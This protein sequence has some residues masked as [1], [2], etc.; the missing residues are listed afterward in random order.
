MSIVSKKWICIGLIGALIASVPVGLSACGKKASVT[1]TTV[2]STASTSQTAVQPKSLEEMYEP[3]LIAFL[4]KTLTIDGKTITAGEYNYHCVSAFQELSAYAQY[5]YYPAT[6]TGTLDLSAVCDLTDNGSGTWGDYLLEYVKK[7]I[8][9]NYILGVLA[10]KNNLT[11]SAETLSEIDT[12]MQE[13]ETQA[14]AAGLTG[15]TFI[16]QYCGDKM[17]VARFRTIIE[18]FYLADLYKTN[19]IDN[20]VFSE[21]ETALP[22]VRH[23]LY[24]AP[25]NGTSEENATEEEVAKAQ[26]NAESTLLQINGYDDMVLIGDKH[27]RD[28]TALEANEYTV[29]R[30]DMVK[31]FEDWC[32]D[33]S[34][35]AGDKEIVRTDFGF[36]VM[37]FVGRTE[38]DEEQKKAIV[39]NIIT[40]E[41][42]AMAKESRYALSESGT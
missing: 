2:A 38:A 6:E 20:Y 3:Q 31:E 1:T 16:E 15:D 25:R 36:H 40:G 17:T 13:I 12:A 26:E 29:S 22:T 10:K 5:G 18:S 14:L 30:G 42:E 21:E 19:F 33:P 23:I 7:D 35:M 39:Q 41:I 32:F 24:S 37:Y 4:N 27:T 8:Q 34:R 28:K 9:Q 11:L